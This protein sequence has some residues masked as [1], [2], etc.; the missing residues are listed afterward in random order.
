MYFGERSYVPPFTFEWRDRVCDVTSKS[1]FCLRFAHYRVLRSGFRSNYNSC[2]V[3]HT[4]F[5]NGFIHKGLLAIGIIIASCYMS[6]YKEPANHSITSS[7]NWSPVLY[8]VNARVPAH[9]GHAT[10]K[11]GSHGIQTQDPSRARRRLHPLSHGHYTCC[12][13]NISFLRA[14]NM[15]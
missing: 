12:N 14:M 10:K 9:I 15:F 7:L 6:F 2:N 1:S 11:V 8:I 5:F 13:Q 3:L 4:L